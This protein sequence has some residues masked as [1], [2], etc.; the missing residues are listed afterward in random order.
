MS[1]RDIIPYK[2]EDSSLGMA[3]CRWKSVHAKSLVADEVL[4]GAKEYIDTKATKEE[5]ARVEGMIAV[6]SSPNYFAR[7]NPFSASGNLKIKTPDVLWININNKGH[8]TEVSKELDVTDPMSWDYKATKRKASTKY[9][10]GAFVYLTLATNTYIYK[11]TT[12]GTTSALTPAFPEEVGETVV[13]GDVVWECTLNYSNADNRAGRDFFIYA[14]YA[15]DTVVPDYVLSVNSTVPYGYSAETTRKVGGFHCLCEAVGTIEGHK[16]S[17]YLKGD[18]IPASVWDLRHRPKTD[19]GGMVYDEGTDIWTSIYLMSW[20]GTAA[21][22]DLELTSKAGA[23]V[24]DGASAEKFHCFKFEQWL[25][26]QQMRLP[27]YQEF[28]H[29]SLGSNQGTSIAGSNDV[30]TTGGFKD[31]EGRRM[32]SHIG[33]EDCCGNLFQYAAQM[34]NIDIKWTQG[35]DINDAQVGG[36]IT[37]GYLSV[38]GGAWN[39]ASFSGSRCFD[40]RTSL[41]EL[42]ARIGC[43]TIAE[44]LLP[45]RGI[46]F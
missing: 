45:I 20:T 11:C 41:L 29:L 25:G 44:P 36:S 16:L 10:V 33:A 42:N 23:V 38:L 35:Y 24:A 6:A 13:D 32:I 34:R 39:S 31:T 21:A 37:G 7:S 12:A 2:N 9:A 19:I 3:D 22:G 46:S 26:N 4:G 27:T 18:I 40:T 8:K 14:L 5:L 1:L 28:V 43:R 15:K 17:G 30:N